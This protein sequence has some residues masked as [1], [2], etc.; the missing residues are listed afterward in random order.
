SRE[1]RLREA[2]ILRTLG[3]GRAQ[4]LAGLLAEFSVLGL[5]AGLLA[6]AGATAIGYVL[7]VQ[8]FNLPYYFNPGLWLIGAVGGTLGVG[9]AGVLGTRSVLDHPPLA[10][11]RRVG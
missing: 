11:L 10:T 5:L 1:A 2:S 3:A 4:V 6:A 8:V 9:L 7:A